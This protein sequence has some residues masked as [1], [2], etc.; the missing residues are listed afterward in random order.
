MN[1][2]AQQ[3]AVLELRLGA[4]KDP[5][6]RL[7][8]A[9]ALARH[10]RRERMSDLTQALTSCP[11]GV[12]E[13]AMSLLHW[14]PNELTTELNPE[15]FVKLASDFRQRLPVRLDALR[16]LGSIGRTKPLTPRTREALLAIARESNRELSRDASRALATDLGFSR[17]LVLAELAKPKPAARALLE[18]LARVATPADF[19]VL[20]QQMQLFAAKPGDETDALIDAVARIPGVEAEAPLLN[21][22]DAYPELRRRIG[23]RLMV[24]P[25]LQAATKARLA[26]AT[27]PDVHLLVSVLGGAPDALAELQAV[28]AEGEPAQRQFAA[29][30]AGLWRDPGTTPQLWSLVNFRDDRFYPNDELVRH[31]AMSALLWIALDELVAARTSQGG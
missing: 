13:E 29:F 4:E 18:R 25:N 14:L 23:L 26:A 6:V 1:P 27:D 21:W 20:V 28:L 8:L 30:L 11:T 7:S 15:T 9:Y 24:R 12:C 16:I 17:E 2:Q 19:P 22:F 5:V 10:G 31:A 3:V